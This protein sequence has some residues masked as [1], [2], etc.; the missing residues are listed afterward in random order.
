VT[1]GPRDKSGKI[2]ITGFHYTRSRDRGHG[3]LFW[4]NAVPKEMKFNVGERG[5]RPP[6]LDGYT[7]YV[8]TETERQAKKF[9]FTLENPN[10]APARPE[11]TETTPP[12]SA[13]VTTGSSARD[14]EEAEAPAAPVTAGP[15]GEPPENWDDDL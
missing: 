13:A 12:P 3:H 14:E 15:T 10:P 6:R 2:D 7:P 5:S 1:H 9:G 4:N 8:H 11:R